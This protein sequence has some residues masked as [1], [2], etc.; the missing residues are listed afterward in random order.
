MH[1]SLNLLP[2]IV[3]LTITVVFIVYRMRR[4]GQRINAGS[5]LHWQ[6][7]PGLAMLIGIFLI[8][9]WVVKRYTPP[10]HMSVIES[11]AMDM[12]DIHTPQGSTPV[13]VMTA[14][15][16]P[17]TS[18]ESYAATASPFQD[19]EIVARVTGRLVKMP[20]YPGDRVLP[21]E[22]AALLDTSEPHSQMEETKANL[23][24][25]RQ[26]LIEARYKTQQAMAQVTDTGKSGLFQQI[27]K[28]S[29]E[30]PT[31]VIAIYVGIAAFVELQSIGPLFGPASRRL[32]PRLHLRYGRTIERTVYNP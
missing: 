4:T 11:S 5:I 17:F 25:T 18:S 27:Q 28:C 10:G 2:L 7:L 20:L 14:M 15:N 8:A 9:R 22:T 6:T 24:M 19:N 30:H 16:M 12:S 23:S 21:G 32:L 13:A 31:V 26:D 1:F 3:A 29:I